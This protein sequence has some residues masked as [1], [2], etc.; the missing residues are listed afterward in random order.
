MLRIGLGIN[1]LEAS[2]PLLAMSNAFASLIVGIGSRLVAETRTLSVDGKHT[3]KTHAWDLSGITVS[4]SVCLAPANW[5]KNVRIDN[6]N[7]F[8]MCSLWLRGV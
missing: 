7:L 8:I 2:L 3:K 4:C 5:N 1:K 6:N